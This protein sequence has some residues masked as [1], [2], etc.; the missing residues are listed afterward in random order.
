MPLSDKSDVASYVID[1]SQSRDYTKSQVCCTMSQSHAR[2]AGQACER[3]TSS[4]HATAQ[5]VQRA[6]ECWT[7]TSSLSCNVSGVAFCWWASACMRRSSSM[8]VIAILSGLGSDAGAVGA[9]SNAACMPRAAALLS[10]SIASVY[11]CRNYRLQKVVGMH[12][13]MV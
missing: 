5:M 1:N 3:G 11:I 12:A 7:F 10:S 13:A 6:S 9:G 8:T 2:T 4:A